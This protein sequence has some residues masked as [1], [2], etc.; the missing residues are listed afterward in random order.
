M[1][2]SQKKFQARKTNKKKTQVSK[3]KNFAIK[4]LINHSITT[5][6]SFHGKGNHKK[7][8]KTT[9]S[10]R[11]NPKNAIKSIETRL[12]WRMSDICLPE[13]T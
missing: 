13:C 1:Y 6:T 11:K 5:S 3:I 7:S 4:K 12:R 2:V 9:K 10:Q 8:I